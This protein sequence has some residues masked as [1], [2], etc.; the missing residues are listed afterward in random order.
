MEYEYLIVELL[1]HYDDQKHLT[2]QLNQLEFH[3]HK[4]FDI[5]DYLVENEL[6]K[7]GVI[8]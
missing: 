7:V 8:D 4:L 1:K 5:S 6:E 2:Y 3:P